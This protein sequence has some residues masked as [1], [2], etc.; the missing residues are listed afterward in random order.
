V[1]L[2]RESTPDRPAATRWEI[3]LLIGPCS[4]E[5]ATGL[6]LAVD[7]FVAQRLG[8]VASLTRWEDDDADA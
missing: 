8:A 4:E 2:A 5:E 1:R 3:G 6:M 7:E